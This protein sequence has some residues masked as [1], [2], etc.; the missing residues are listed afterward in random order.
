MRTTELRLMEWAWVDLARRAVRIPAHVTKPQRSREVPLNADA[1]AVLRRRFEARRHRRFVFPNAAGMNALHPGTIYDA[2]ARAARRAGLPY[3]QGVR[4]GFRLYDS[5][6]TAAT[7][8]LQSGA[9]MGSVA[10]VLGNSKEIMM[11]VY[12]HS[13][14]GSR[15]GRSRNWRDSTPKLTKNRQ[16]IQM[17]A[18]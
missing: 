16:R 7:R 8:M 13:S 15:R 4:G 14:S 6:H 3:G 5:R 2:L 17:K 1:L 10:D 12:N 18:A 11:R 9:E